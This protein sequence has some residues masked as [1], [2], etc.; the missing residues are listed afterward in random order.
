MSHYQ[1]IA[2]IIEECLGFA[3]RF[4]VRKMEDMSYIGL[5]TLMQVTLIA[6]KKLMTYICVLLSTIDVYIAI[7]QSFEIYA[8]P[9]SSINLANHSM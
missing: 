9:L 6:F 7:N 4:W 8:N 5:K 3:F 1:L 2:A